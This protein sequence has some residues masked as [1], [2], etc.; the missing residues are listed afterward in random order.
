MPDANSGSTTGP[1][2]SGRPEMPTDYRETM[3]YKA[4]LELEMWKEQEEGKFEDQV[5]S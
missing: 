4:A 3:E 5:G 1:A 2:P